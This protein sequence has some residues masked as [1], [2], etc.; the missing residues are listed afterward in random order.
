MKKIALSLVLFCLCLLTACGG[1]KTVSGAVVERV[2][3]EDG[4]PASFVLQTDGGDR[5]GILLTEDTHVISWIGGVTRDDLLAPDREGFTLSVSCGRAAPAMTAQS[6]ET[7]RAYT[8]K[9][10][11][12]FEALIREN[13]FVLPDGVQVDLWA[14]SSAS[15]Y[16][17]KDGTALLLEEHPFGPDRVRVGGIESYDDL[18]GT[19]QKNVSAFYDRQGLLYSLEEELERA[20]AAY[21][22]QAGEG[23]FDAYRVGQQISPTASTE[24]V[25]CFL[26]TVTLPT[27]SRTYTEL[28]L[29]AVFDR[30]TG[31]HLSGWELFSCGER[32]AKETILDLAGVT[33]PVLRAELEAAF[34]PD[35]LVLFPDHLEVSFPR[36][37]LP[38]KDGGYMMGLDYDETLR[39]I[40]YGWA[41]PRPGT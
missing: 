22:E 13:A 12:I 33:D 8:A 25:M 23:G 10:V 9:S 11:E 37:A 41:V 7:V 14:R 2:L 21:S 5:V 39:G 3:P 31:E 32:E 40:L 30:E 35:Y 34:Q 24:T 6:G 38:S 17:L 29:G 20:Y 26:T 16:R 4:G 27:G 18:S 19:A 15:L 36:D 28:R 1:G